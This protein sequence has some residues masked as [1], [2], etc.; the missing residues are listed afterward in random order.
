MKSSTLLPLL[1][2]ILLSARASA[3]LTTFTVSDIPFF[4]SSG[5]MGA[6]PPAAFGNGDTVSISVTFED[7]ITA[8]AASNSN[9]Y[10]TN[11]VNWTNN[12]IVNFTATVSRGGLPIYQANLSPN[13]S[14]PQGSLTNGIVYAE[15]SAGASSLTLDLNEQVVLI[16]DISYAAPGGGTQ[17]IV[18]SGLSMVLANQGGTAGLVDIVPGN[19]YSTG[20]VI[21]GASPFGPGSG[22]VG[23]VS[24]SLLGDG[25][26][27][28]YVFSQNSVPE[29]SVA[30]LGALAALSMLRRR[31]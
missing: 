15:N 2:G 27:Y 25:R 18:I 31:R 8:N 30:C 29:P 12:P 21:G 24:F 13:L 17:N 4:Y 26:L 6:N 7:S 19:S 10:Y 11:F 23:V 22:R 5:F 1:L 14:A 28:N 16:P 3:A 20:Q 9:A